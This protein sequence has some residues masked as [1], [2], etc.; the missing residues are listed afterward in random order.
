MLVD[1]IMMKKVCCVLVLLCCVR[2]RWMRFESRVSMSAFISDICAKRVYNRDNAYTGIYKLLTIPLSCA[3]SC[4]MCFRCRISLSGFIGGI[5]A[6]CAWLGQCLYTGFCKALSRYV[7]PCCAWSC[8]IQDFLVTFYQR[9]LREARIFP[10]P[11][12]I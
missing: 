2:G 9:H 10:A 5:C 1:G 12:A 8:L 3:R 11:K 7:P 6:K 4:L